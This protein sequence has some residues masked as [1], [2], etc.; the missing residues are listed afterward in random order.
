MNGKKILEQ[1]II[2][3]LTLLIVGLV[4]IGGNIVWDGATTVGDKVEEAKIDIVEGINVLAGEIAK[5][6]HRQDS[7]EAVNKAFMSRTPL[8]VQPIALPPQQTKA[9]ILNEI[10]V[11][12]SA[13]KARRIK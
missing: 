5:I 3:V 1:I 9:N 12:Q 13:T 2:Q 11:R 10:D 4:A 6:S 8:S 7:L